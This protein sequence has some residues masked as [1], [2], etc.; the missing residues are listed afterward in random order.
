M[1]FK[2]T[3]D[4]YIPKD[5]ESTQE[6]GDAIVYLYDKTKPC[7]MAFKG[8]AQKPTWHYI[9]T[10]YNGKTAEERRQETINK[11]FHNIDIIEHDRQERKQRQQTEIA[12]HNIKPGDYF[13][14]SWGYDQTNYDYLVVNSISPTGKTATCQ[15]ANPIYMGEA[16]QCDALT[17]GCAYGI[18][19]RMKI[20]GK[21]TL[22]GSYPYCCD[23]DDF[24]MGYFSKTRLGEVHYQTMPEFGH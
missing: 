1:R 17:P 7:A 19:F 18:K 14:T 4:F 16:G 22:R 5:Y 12:N 24:R 9:F 8:K 3:R 13:V 23:Q 11:W 6:H 15:M 10:G 21:D 20:D 2:L